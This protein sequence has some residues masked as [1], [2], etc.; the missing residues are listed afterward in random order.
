MADCLMTTDTLRLRP[1]DLISQ[2]CAFSIFVTIPSPRSAGTASNPTIQQTHT[3]QTNKANDKA[4]TANNNKAENAKA[5]NKDPRNPR[6]TFS[7]PILVFALAIFYPLGLLASS[8][9]WRVIPNH[10]RKHMKSMMKLAIQKKIVASPND[11]INN[12]TAN[13]HATTNTMIK[14]MTNNGD[15]STNLAWSCTL[16][17]P[18]RERRLS[19]ADCLSSTK[20]LRVST[21][22]TTS[23]SHAGAGG[24]KRH[25]RAGPCTS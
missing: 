24:S 20:R 11:N 12:A 21:I 1:P 14:T 6:T 17:H 18:R 2:K 23:A 13:E 16:G 25:A 15:N 8:I 9:L 19:S 4:R 5:E 22:F 7:R 10:C 3:M